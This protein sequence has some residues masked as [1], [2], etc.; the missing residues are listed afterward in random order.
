TSRITAIVTDTPVRAGQKVASDTLLCQL[1][2]ENRRASL[3]EAE[4]RMKAAQVEW[5]AIERLYAQKLTSE[6]DLAS[7]EAALKNAKAY[8]ERAQLQLKHTQIRAPFAGLVDNVAAEQGALLNQG[9]T[10]ALLLD[11]DPLIVR[12]TISEAEVIDVRAGN[13]I[14]VAL[15]N[16]TNVDGTLT[17]VSSSADENSRT[18]KVEAEIPNQDLSLRAGLSAD[19]LIYA[20]PQPAHLIP[21]SSLMLDP[22]EGI[23]VKILDKDDTVQQLP[24]E[25]LHDSLEG[26]WVKGLPTTVRVITVGHYYVTPNQKVEGIESKLVKPAKKVQ[27]SENESAPASAPDSQ[28]STFTPAPLAQ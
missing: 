6:L 19:M 5:A 9:Q 11:L 24:V 28:V 15:R 4:G 18:F 26:I 12:G 23:V 8:L 22:N 7:K 13:Q 10:C 21:A 16:N 2:E 20:S 3:N 27:T 25:L 17:F 1:A 14:S